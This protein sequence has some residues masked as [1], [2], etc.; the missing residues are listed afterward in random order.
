MKYV[1]TLAAAVLIGLGGFTVSAGGAADGSGLVLSKCSA[2]HSLKRICRGLGKKDL[3][4]WQKTNQRM[5]DMGM[6]VTSEELDLISSYLAT[7][8]PGSG[9]VCN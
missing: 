3:A 2:C 5:A 6:T 1:L 7:A 4:A 9:P 8:N